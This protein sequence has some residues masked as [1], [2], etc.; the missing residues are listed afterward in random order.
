[1]SELRIFISV[2]RILV[3]ITQVVEG[4]YTDSDRKCLEQYLLNKYDLLM[5]ENIQEIKDFNDALRQ[6][7][8]F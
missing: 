2:T 8:L 7:P 4:C 6:F 1:M 3:Q 5:P